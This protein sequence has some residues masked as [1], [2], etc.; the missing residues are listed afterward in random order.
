MPAQAVCAVCGL[1]FAPSPRSLLHPHTSTLNRG[2]ARLEAGV[3]N[4]SHERPSSVLHTT[5]TNHPP[6]SAGRAGGNA[7][8]YPSSLSEWPGTECA[9]DLRLASQ[10]QACHRAAALGAEISRDLSTRLHASTSLPPHLSPPQTRCIQYLPSAC[11]IHK[12]KVSSL[13]RGNSFSPKGASDYIGA[14]LQTPYSPAE[15]VRWARGRSVRRVRAGVRAK[16]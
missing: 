2:I 8:H 10:S 7:E 14:G 13:S 9:L 12:G 15:A 4:T 5:H 11:A 1:A 16:P 6:C 3:P